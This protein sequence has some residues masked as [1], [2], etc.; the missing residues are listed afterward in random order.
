MPEFTSRKE[1][2]KFLGFTV[3]DGK[4]RMPKLITEAVDLAIAEGKVTIVTPVS[5]NPRKPKAEKPVKEKADKPKPTN[6]I[7]EVRSP[8]YDLTSHYAVADDGTEI[9]MREV[10]FNVNCGVSLLYCQCR[11]VMHQQSKV[12]ARKGY[13]YVFATIKER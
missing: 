4:G 10:C 8:E 9:G 5:A 12:L 11:R 3:I 1:A 2:A 6:G 13:G 7:I